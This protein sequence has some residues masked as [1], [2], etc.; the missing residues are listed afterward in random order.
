[1][2]MILDLIARK[3]PTS[4]W[5]LTDEEVDRLNPPQLD[6]VVDDDTG[7]FYIE[8]STN[9]DWL[10]MGQCPRPKNK[11]EW[12]IHHL[13]MGLL[14]R[15]PTHKVFW[16]SLLNIGDCRSLEV[17][18]REDLERIARGEEPIYLIIG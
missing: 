12:F 9:P 10:E 16:Y 17:N 15:Y 1:M 3:I 4:W 6:S 11:R 14:M 8:Y 2:K 13:C 7:K 18:L 5:R